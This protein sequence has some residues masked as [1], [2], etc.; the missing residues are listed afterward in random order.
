MAKTT[1]RARKVKPARHSAGDSGHGDTSLLQRNLPAVSVRDLVVHDD[2]L[3]IATHGR[4]F[5]IM[6]NVAPLRQILDAVS[7]GRL[8][9]RRDQCAGQR[10]SAAAMAAEQSW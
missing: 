6:D 4:G 9:P 7:A 2:D 3:V 10:E 1:S 8:D 5:W